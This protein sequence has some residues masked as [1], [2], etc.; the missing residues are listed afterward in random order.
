MARTQGV[1]SIPPPKK[2]PRFDFIFT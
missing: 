1:G 2:I